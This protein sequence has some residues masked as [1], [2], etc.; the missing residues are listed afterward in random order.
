MCSQASRL[1]IDHQ[2]IC[3]SGMRERETDLHSETRLAKITAKLSK[4]VLSSLAYLANLLYMYDL[5][6]NKLVVY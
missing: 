3:V 1:D 5:I 2:G 6:L 4:F